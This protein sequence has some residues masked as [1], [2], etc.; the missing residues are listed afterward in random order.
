MKPDFDNKVLLIQNLTTGEIEPVN[1]YFCYH[2]N[3]ILQ[4]MIL[5][6]RLKPYIDR[7]IKYAMSVATRDLA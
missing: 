6:S 4:G 2:D 3:T 1:D 7:G 5:F